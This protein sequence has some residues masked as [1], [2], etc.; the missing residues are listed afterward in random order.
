MIVDNMAEIRT[1]A[2][3]FRLLPHIG[4]KSY[5]RPFRCVNCKWRFL[6]AKKIE[7]LQTTY[8]VKRRDVG[9]P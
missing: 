8:C 9:R 2:R 3:R 1:Y 7:H 6:N 4:T 5:L